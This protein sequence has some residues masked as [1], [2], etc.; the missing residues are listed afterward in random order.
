VID[1]LVGNFHLATGLR[2]EGS[3]FVCDGVLEKQGLEKS[4]AKVL[5][6][7]I[8]DG[9]RSTKSTKNVGLDEFYHDLVIIGLGGHDFYPLGDIIHPYQNIL[10]PKRW[11]EGSYKVD[12]PNIKNLNNEDGV[13]W[14]HV[15]LR[16]T[17]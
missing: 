17:S 1:L 4:V 11:W 2:M 13:Q 3:G 14:H 7:A 8:D 5:I 16:H 12:T 9:P 15:P 10:I 6:S